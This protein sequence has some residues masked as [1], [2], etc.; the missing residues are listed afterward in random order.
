MQSKTP[1]Q[2]QIMI[3]KVV[4]PAM[5]SPNKTLF[6]G[7]IMSWIDEVAFMSARRHSGQ[8]TVV[9]A[10][11]DNI[12]FLY[13]IKEGQQVVLTAQVNYVGRSSMEIGV[14]VEIENAFS[15]KLTHTNSAY[16]TF[17]ALDNRGRPV[18]V[19]KLT[20]ESEDDQ[21]RY[22]EAK[23]RVKVRMRL[24]RHLKSKLKISNSTKKLLQKQTTQFINPVVVYKEYIHKIGSRLK[25]QLEKINKELF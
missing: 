16:L 22:E 9:T 24:R 2:S 3:R 14:R 7:Y 18:S 12:S 23:L 4:A 15:G 6:G 20:L 25:T 10:S 1:G 11:I 8:S 19:P 21:R 13:P 17:V 5:L